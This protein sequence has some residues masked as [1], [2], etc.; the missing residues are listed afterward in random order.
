MSVTWQDDVVSP[1]SLVRLHKEA[2]R[3]NEEQLA[4]L[5]QPC[6]RNH[7]E[8]HT[9]SGEQAQRAVLVRVRAPDPDGTRRQQQSFCLFDDA[10]GVSTLSCSGTLIELG[11]RLVVLASARVLLPFLTN[12]NE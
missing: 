5:T 2:L 9:R 11:D 1:A 10:T 7:A 3:Q 6:E 8:G 12:R 4:S